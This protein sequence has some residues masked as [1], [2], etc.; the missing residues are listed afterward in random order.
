MNPNAREVSRRHFLLAAA[1]Q[2]DL[3][4]TPRTPAERN[5]PPLGLAWRVDED[6]RGRR[7][8]HHAGATIG[9]RASLVIY[10][11]QGLAIALASNVMVTPGNVL[12]PSSDLADLF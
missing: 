12:G 1:A 2:R 6:P 3:L 9:G 4:F 8:Y 7:R 10:P 11:D 5:S